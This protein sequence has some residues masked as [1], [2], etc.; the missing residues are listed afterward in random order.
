[1]PEFLQGTAFWG[2]PHD[3]TVFGGTQV[4]NNYHA[5][6]IGLGKNLG[7]LGAISADLTEARATLPDDTQH[8]G[9]SLRFLYNKS[10]NQWGTNLQL[11][12][13]RYS[14]KNFYTL[15]DTAWS[16][17]SG[18]TLVSQ[19]QPVQITPQ[20]TDAYNLNYSKRGRFQATLTQQ[21][22]K[23]STVYLTGSQQS[24]WGTGQSDEQLQLGYNSTIGDISWG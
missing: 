1:M 23:T 21:V 22:G 5:L 2:L 4:S 7:D 17:M 13:Y 8:Q 12:G 11:L 3:W 18:F 16:Q 6:D 14:T 19:D 24:Y 9:Q 10:I 15:A 20:I